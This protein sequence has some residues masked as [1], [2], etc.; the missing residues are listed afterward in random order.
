MS[1]TAFEKAGLAGRVITVTGGAGGIGRAAALLCAS[2]GAQVVIADLDEAGGA[3]V[4]G[5]IERAGGRA[6]FIRTDVTIEDEVRGMVAFAV[7][8]FGGLHGAFNNAG[9]ML[10]GTPLTDFPIDLW[11]KGVS[12][13]LTSVFLC[14]KHQLRHMLDHGGGA[15]VNN[16]SASGAVGIPMAVNYVATKHGVIGVTRAAAAEVSG[17]GVRVNAILPGAVETPLLAEAVKA[18][19]VREAVIA[20]HPI[21]RI[22]QPEEIAEAAAWLLSDASSF[23]TGACVTLDGGYTAI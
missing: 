22:S 10:G 17:R 8:T 9:L 20:G 16:A 21:G 19:G 13:N 5:E 23:V 15:I 11:E 4:V 12:I 2:R 3:Q 7:S 6:A 1:A 18:P 14:V